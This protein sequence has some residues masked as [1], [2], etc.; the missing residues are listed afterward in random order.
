M[1]THSTAREAKFRQAAFVYLHVGILYLAFVWVLHS[2][3]QFPVNRGSIA[4]WMPLG[5]LIVGAVFWGLFFRKN[6][7]VAR[8]VWA[9]AAFRC[10]A[11]IEGAFLSSS[12]ILPRSF[13]LTAL[14]VVLVNLWTLARAGWDL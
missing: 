4:V 2:T 6:V 3:G 8:I 14:V 7:W 5:A 9:L 11:L 1:T 10:P 12:D 13:F